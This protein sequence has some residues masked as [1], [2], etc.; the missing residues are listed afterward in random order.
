MQKICKSLQELLAEKQYRNI[1]VNNN[2]RFQSI[3]A[4]RGLKD[5]APCIMESLL[6]FQMLRAYLKK[7]SAQDLG[8]DGAA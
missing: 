2:N 4:N 1:V 6:T 3:T 5:F 8:T 7:L